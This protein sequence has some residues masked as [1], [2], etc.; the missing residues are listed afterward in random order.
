MIQISFL[1]YLQLYIVRQEAVIT[2]FGMIT[3]F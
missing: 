3:I 2:V 1:V